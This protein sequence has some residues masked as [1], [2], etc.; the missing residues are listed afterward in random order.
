M[1]WWVVDRRS[2]IGFIW[3]ISA[4]HQLFVSSNNNVYFLISCI[5]LIGKGAI[6]LHIQVM[7][8]F[9]LPN[10]VKWLV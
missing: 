1:Q 10:S 6:A 4:H 5:D 3:R 8:C 9:N 7:K 2:K